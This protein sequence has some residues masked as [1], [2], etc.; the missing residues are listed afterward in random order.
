MGTL[1]WDE[2]ATRFETAQ[3]WWVATSGPAGPHAVPVWGVVVGGVL[4]FYGEESTV[5]SR[6]LAV[7]PRLV[8]HL[9]SASDVLVVHGTAGVS[10]FAHEH[11]DVNAAYAAKYID[12]TDREYLP[13]A[14]GMTA[15]RLYVVTPTRA[16]AWRLGSSEEWDNRRWRAAPD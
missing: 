15:A 2:I 12:P 13:D 7:D 6:N 16:I 10:G 5:R 3:S 11:A 14:P 4:Q 9:E 8:L 1:D